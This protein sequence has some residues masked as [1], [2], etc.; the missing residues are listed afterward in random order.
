MKRSL[1]RIAPVLPRY[2]SP[3][4]RPFCRICKLGIAFEVHAVQE[5]DE[6]DRFAMVDRGEAP[7]FVL[8]VD[9]DYDIREM[10]AA[11]LELEG[12]RVTAVSNGAEA[13]GLLKGAGR[14]PDLI[15]LDLMMPIMNGYQFR[16]EQLRDSDLAAIPVLILTGFGN[17]PSVASQLG[18]AGG[19][20]KPVSFAALSAAVHTFGCLGGSSSN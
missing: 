6:E 3:P 18:A 11:A 20:N 7:G 16:A 19:L 2:V 13:L 9:D 10:M 5:E 12:F 17:A 15:I 4:W 14:R 8:V 1:A